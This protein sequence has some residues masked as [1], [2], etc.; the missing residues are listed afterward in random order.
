MPK[1]RATPSRLRC[2]GW[3]IALVAAVVL[4]AGVGAVLVLSA[5]LIPLGIGRLPAR[6]ALDRLR[7][8]ADLHRLWA[9]RVMGVSIPRSYRE[10]LPSAT[11]A[12]LAAYRADPAT[13][14]D[15]RWLAADLTGGQLLA[16]IP[17]GGVFTAFVGSGY[18][19]SRWMINTHRVV[20]LDPY[21][22]HPEVGPQ[23]L[24]LVVIVLALLGTWFLARPA[25]RGYTWLQR[26]LLGPATTE[27]LVTRIEQLTRSRDD[28]VDTQAAE[29][30]R[31]ERDL[32]DGA[33]ARLVSLGM[34]LGM[35][36]KLMAAD[37]GAAQQLLAEAKQA[38]GLALSELRELVRGIHPPI[39][40]DRGLAGAAQA[41]ALNSPIPVELAVDLP[42][43]PP[44]PVES[45]MYFALTEVLTNLVKHSGAASAWIR[46]SYTDGRLGVMVGD[47][48]RGGATM[49]EGGGLAGVARRLAGFDGMVHVA[50]P[51]GGPTIVTME[52]PCQLAFALS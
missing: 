41:L 49:P 38:T 9:A 12:R 46:L 22:V 28:A 21:D 7:D 19:F 1:N 6:W 35:A 4:E 47:D 25:M 39:L 48:G 52:L 50:S 17:G 51:V 36:E 3:S 14:R 32:H 34:S 37:P 11:N 43:R 40:A 26:W 23:W 31:I 16:A 30:R 15:V 45:A 24:A 20:D 44:A 29:I 42:G 8:L 33:Q 18:L 10:P 5:L 2:V 13:W 27:R